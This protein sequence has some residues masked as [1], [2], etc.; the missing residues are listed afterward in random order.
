MVADKAKND[1]SLICKLF[2]PSWKQLTSMQLASNNG[3]FG[4]ITNV[5]SNNYPQSAKTIKKFFVSNMPAQAFTQTM[6]M[7]G[8]FT[9]QLPGD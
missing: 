3:P 8:I 7:P 5:Q 4:T 6:A 1:P 9:F 2:L